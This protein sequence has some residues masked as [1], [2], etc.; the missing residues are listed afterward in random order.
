MV[1]TRLH[2][3][4]RHRTTRRLNKLSV[5]NSM[6]F[7]ASRPYSLG[8]VGYPPIHYCVLLC[9][10]CDIDWALCFV[11]NPACLCCHSIINVCMYVSLA[12]ISYASTVMWCVISE[13]KVNWPYVSSTAGSWDV[14][15]ATMAETWE[16]ALNTNTLMLYITC[17]HVTLKC[18]GL[19]LKAKQEVDR[20][21]R[22]V[23]ITIW[24]FSKMS[25][26]AILD[27]FEA[28]IAPFDP[29]SPKTPP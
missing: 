29:P 17:T 21:T 2:A 18:V 23:Y 22:C 3:K 13:G 19:N 20:T 24:N 4:F 25:A 10:Y 1:V 9:F 26:A 16:T 11:L 6:S 14:L 8:T 15:T 12:P 28:E 7:P 5:K 27:L